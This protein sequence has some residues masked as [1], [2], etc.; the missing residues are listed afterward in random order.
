MRQSPPPKKNTG[1]VVFFHFGDG[2]KI[3]DSAGGDQ[4]ATGE[5]FDVLGSI[6]VLYRA[7]IFN[8]NEQK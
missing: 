3:F 8:F 2:A 5:N 1:E 4:S 6:Y 7:K